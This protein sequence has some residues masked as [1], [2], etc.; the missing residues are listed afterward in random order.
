GSSSAVV[1]SGCQRSFFGP[2]G[3]ASRRRRVA[4]GSGRRPST[5]RS[6]HPPSR[7]GAR[8]VPGRRPGQRHWSAGRAARCRSRRGSNPGP[9]PASPAPAASRG[10]RR[11]TASGRRRGGRRGGDRLALGDNSNGGG[12]ERRQQGGPQR[13]DAGRSVRSQN[14]T[15]RGGGRGRGG[16]GPEAVLLEGLVQGDAGHADAEGVADEVDQV[17][18]AGGGVAEEGPGDGPG[19]ARQELA[20][21]AAIQAV[22]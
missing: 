8:P 3:D 21:G 14:G 10:R 18:A 15:A 22:V 1:N 20:V 2:G 13:R 12:Q 9:W 6:R 4:T 16:A 7:R 17:G 5:A 11:R 19:I